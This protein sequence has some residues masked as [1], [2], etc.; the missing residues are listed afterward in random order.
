MLNCIKK[1]FRS[2]LAIKFS[3]SNVFL[4]LSRVILSKSPFF[5]FIF[6]TII[7]NVDLA[8]IMTLSFSRLILFGLFSFLEFLKEWCCQ[9][10]PV[11]WGLL[12]YQKGWE[13][14]IDT[15]PPAKKEVPKF[16]IAILVTGIM[17]DVI[18][19]QTR[20]WTL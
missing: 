13:L 20:Y 15:H 19:E 7:E 6:P 1:E 16:V 4:F 3:L 11:S 5:L 17:Y 18:S 8:T 9:I 12:S 14:K 2:K 10:N